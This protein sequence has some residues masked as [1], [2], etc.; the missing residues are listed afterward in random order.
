MGSRCHCN[1]KVINVGEDQAPME[2]GP[3]TIYIYTR[4]LSYG[5]GTVHD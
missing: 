3:I 1:H 4:V 2:H 5:I